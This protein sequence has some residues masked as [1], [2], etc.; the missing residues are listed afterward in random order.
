M[1]I[2]K[3]SPKAAKQLNIK[4]TEQVHARDETVKQACLAKGWV[5]TLQP[6]FESWLN[7]QLAA[8]EKELAAAEKQQAKQASEA[9]V[10]A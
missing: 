1:P 10:G 8:A 5:F 4:I 9:G 3:K 2:I 7:A 6:D